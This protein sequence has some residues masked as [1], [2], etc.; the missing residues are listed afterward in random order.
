MNAIEGVIDGQFLDLVRNGNL[1][2]AGIPVMMGNMEDEAVS[3]L[4]L[5][6]KRI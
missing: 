2:S 6:T 1:P 5:R 4:Q 3:V